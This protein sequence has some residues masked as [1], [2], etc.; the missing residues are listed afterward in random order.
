MLGS[1]IGAAIF[2]TLIGPLLG[3]LAVA[4]GT[5][6]VFALVGGIAVALA[7]WVRAHAEPAP[8]SSGER[9]APARP[10]VTRRNLPGKLRSSPGLALGAWLITLEA[11]TIGATSALLPLRLSRLG[12]SGIAIGATFVLA[13]GLATL[14]A[15]IVGRLTDRRGARVPIIVGLICAAALIGLLPA[16]QSWP[17]LAAL[18]VIALGGPLTAFMIPAVSIMTVSAE[19]AGIALLVATTTVNLAYATGETIG[20]PVA[21]SLSQ[22]TSDT[23][24][25]LGLGGLMLLTLW[26]V[27]AARLDRS[28]PPPAPPSAPPA[29]AAPRAAGAH[30]IIAGALPAPTAEHQMTR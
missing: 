21:A 24:P 25:L 29:A 5:K 17:V 8:E 11:I 13:S 14:L 1:V 10:A 4:A 9:A 26:P 22:A 20:A 23:V 12:A 27:I 3:I 16:P 19:R 2:G 18:S 28:P 7:I 15:P 6:L 30:A